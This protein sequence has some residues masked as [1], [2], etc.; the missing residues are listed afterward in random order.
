MFDIQYYRP[1]GLGEGEETPTDIFLRRLMNNNM[2]LYEK[3]LRSMQLLMMFGDQLRM[4]YSKHLR[5]GI[6]ELRTV[7]GNDI[8]RL[9]Y[10]FDEDSVVL[11]THG[12]VK[13][14]NKTSKADIEY[15]IRAKKTHFR[16]KEERE[17]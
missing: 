8:T 17:K 14:T 2:K 7:F 13:K 3:T 6:F 11:M 9:F 4:P 1:D 12:I 15:A 5:D 16:R 10:F